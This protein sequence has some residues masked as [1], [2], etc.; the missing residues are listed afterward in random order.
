MAFARRGFN[1]SANSKTAG[2]SI[3]VATNTYA[4][5]A[6]DLIIIT[7]GADNV[8]VGDGDFSEVSSVVGPASL[9]FTKAAE[10]TNGQGAAAA[11]ATVSV[12]YAIC[13]AG[14]LAVG[15]SFTVTFAN[16]VAVKFVGISG[17]S[18]GAT[19]TV[20]VEQT[21][22]GTNDAQDPGALTSFS[23]NNVEHLHLRATAWEGA[24]LTWT[25]TATWVND[26]A[27]ST[28]G[29][30]ATGNIGV[31][32]EGKVS[33]STGETSNP[34]LSVANDNV[35]VLI[36]FVE[37]AGG[38]NLTQGVTDSVTMSDDAAGTREI[39]RTATVNDSVAMSDALKFDRDMTIAETLA[40]ADALGFDRGLTFADTVGLADAISAGLAFA[41]NVNDTVT[42]ADAQALVRGL[43]IPLADS[44]T[45]SDA[46]RFDRAMSIA[47]TLA[48]ADLVVTGE[49]YSLSI[50][51]TLAIADSIAQA[52]GKEVTIADTLALADSLATSRGYGVTVADTLALADA[53][54]TAQGMNLSIAD[55]LALA[56]ALGTAQGRSLSINDAV[57]MADALSREFGVNPADVVTMA[58]A[59][60][61][62]RAITLADALTLS[63]S[64]APTGAGQLLVNLSDSV[65]LADAVSF[66]R[67]IQV[68]ISDTV[69]PSDVIVAAAAHN[70]GL[71]D[72][73]SIADAINTASAIF[74]TVD[75]LVVAADGLAFERAISLAESLVVSDQITTAG[76]TNFLVNVADAL[77]IT[78]EVATLKFHQQ[79]SAA[80]IFAQWEALGPR[81]VKQGAHERRRRYLTPWRPPTSNR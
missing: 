54:A 15:S 32:I 72:P 68:G 26:F 22:V 75:D 42:M 59:L 36:A 41:V 29:G 6:G 67:S 64:V 56:D 45:M 73:L 28:T 35:S 77:G 18:K 58:D 12:W 63:D 11:G 21:A 7:I 76:A 9:A 25:V 55:T 2:T 40:V 43:G 71:A 24:A 16:S 79:P 10:Y 33:T 57:T 14:G 50:G 52:T 65:T 44:V 31:G 5:N 60:K 61:F 53:L 23:L 74:L 46:Q 37:V 70:L 80:E 19:T 39:G 13:P 49:G 34:T 62:D 30:S 51:D 69:T 27:G 17:Y 20:S 66:I 38:A 8:G 1:G 3:N 47:D 81:R 4:F 48:L 78:D